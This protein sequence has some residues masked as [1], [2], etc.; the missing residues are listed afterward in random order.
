MAQVAEAQ[1]IP[2]SAISIEP[3][4]MDTI[5]NACY[6]NRIMEDH[7]WH[8]AEIISSGFHLPRAGLI[9]QRLPLDGASTRRR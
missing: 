2:A 7:G 3:R 9:F 4:A 8:S 5:Q 1:G 6:S